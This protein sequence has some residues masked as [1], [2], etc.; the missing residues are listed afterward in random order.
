MVDGG[1]SGAVGN[2][3]IGWMIGQSHFRAIC[4][5]SCSAAGYQDPDTFPQSRRW[6]NYQFLRRSWQ[7]QLRSTF[8]GAS[9]ARIGKLLAGRWSF[10]PV[11]WSVAFAL[12]VTVLLFIAVLW[13]S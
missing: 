5:L 9:M 7:L 6:F 12:I 3:T 10:G 8:S 1:R 13:R 4:L 11:H 2:V